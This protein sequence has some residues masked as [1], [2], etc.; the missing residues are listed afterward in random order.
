V[1]SVINE[2]NFDEII[3]NLQLASQKA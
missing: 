1:L 3:T 2:H